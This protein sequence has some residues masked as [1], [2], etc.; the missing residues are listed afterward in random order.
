M[1]AA[2]KYSIAAKSG[3]L[4]LESSGS[5]A[6]GFHTDDNSTSGTEVSDTEP[7]SDSDDE[8]TSLNHVSKNDDIYT[9]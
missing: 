6:E 1:I 5:S 9:C 7:E 3:G 4:P 8:L 2:L